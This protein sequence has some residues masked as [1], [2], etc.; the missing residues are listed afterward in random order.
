MNFKKLFLIAKG[1]DS[2][3]EVSSYDRYVGIGAFN[4]L[5]VNPNKAEQEK[6]YGR[7]LEKEPEYNTQQERDGKTTD[8]ARVSFIITTTDDNVNNGIDITETYNIFLRDRVLTSNKEF[9]DPKVKVIDGYGQT[10]WVTE[11]QLTKQEVPVQSNGNFAKIIPPF[12]P[13]V[14]GED[15]LIDFIRAFLAIPDAMR[16]KEGKWVAESNL[17]DCRISFESTAKFFKGDFSEIKKAIS[18]RPDNKIKLVMGVKTT[19][20]NRLFQ[21][22]LV[23]KPLKFSQR[24]TSATRTLEEVKSNGRYPNTEFLIEPLR[25]YKLEPTDLSPDMSEANVNKV[26]DKWFS[27]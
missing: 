24:I 8:V 3:K 16:Y 17:D 4:V 12:R 20:D 23:E 21:D 18:M 10:A 19:E 14:D 1:K 26:R 25:V 15:N 11:E 13:M 6:I 2:S 22:F 27:K 5:A 9:S 7:E